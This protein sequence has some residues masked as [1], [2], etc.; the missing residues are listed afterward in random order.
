MTAKG[1]VR[2][3]GISLPEEWVLEVQKRFPDEEVS[4]VIGV[5]ARKGFTQWKKEH[6]IE[7]DEL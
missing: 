3:V 5:L 4:G 1:Q 2:L 7:V 6:W